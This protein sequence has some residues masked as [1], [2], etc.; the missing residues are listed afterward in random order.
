MQILADQLRVIRRE[1]KIVA[2]P[3]GRAEKVDLAPER[4]GREID[5]VV[6]HQAARRHQRIFAEVE[7]LREADRGDGITGV[8]EKDRIDR[9]AR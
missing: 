8:A 7:R 6:E 5:G 2:D 1:G 3:A 4:V 9:C